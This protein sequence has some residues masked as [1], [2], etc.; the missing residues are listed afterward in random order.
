[1]SD[2]D[3][4]ALLALVTRAEPGAKAP[5]LPDE[6]ERLARAND[7]RVRVLR[8]PSIEP[9][10]ARVQQV[11]MRLAPGTD[12]GWEQHEQASQIFVVVAGTGVLRRGRS[13][14]ALDTREA[15]ATERE[16]RAG[17]TWLVEPRTWH[18]VE[19]T[20]ELRLVTYYTFTEPWTHAYGSVVNT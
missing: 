12:I 8:T 1:M 16:V 4:R 11:A 7:A 3:K 2:A 10:S 14:D 5:P 19:A 17:A 15:D 9:E 20:S 13:G 6:L 18:N